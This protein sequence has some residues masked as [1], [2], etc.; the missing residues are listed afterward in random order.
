MVNGLLEPCSETLAQSGVVIARSLVDMQQNSVPLR[1]GNFTNE[2]VIC[3]VHKGI[4]AAVC[5]T[6]TDISVQELQNK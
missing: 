6:V 3:T 4:V 2:T 5:E 1:V